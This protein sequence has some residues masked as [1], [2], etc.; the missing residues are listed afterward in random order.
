MA[1]ATAIDYLAM[2]AYLDGSGGW[3]PVVAN[4]RGS[5]ASE[6]KGSGV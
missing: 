3:A 1:S 6:G 4:L 2:L 5:M